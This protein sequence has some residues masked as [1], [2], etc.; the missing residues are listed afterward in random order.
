MP[1]SVRGRASPRWVARPP[2]WC[3]NRPGDAVVVLVEALWVADLGIHGAMYRMTTNLRV[4]RC[5]NPAR[6]D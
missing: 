6:I 1:S 4:S 5:K 2:V 3:R